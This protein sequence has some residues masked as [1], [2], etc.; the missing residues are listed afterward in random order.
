M[1]TVPAATLGETSC[2]VRNSPGGRRT[3]NSGVIRYDE[4]T[5]E[6]LVPRRVPFTLPGEVTLT[7][8][9]EIDR[10]PTLSSS[11]ELD[12]TE[13][14]MALWSDLERRRYLAE[15]QEGIYGSRRVSHRG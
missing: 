12:Q 13:E 3:I 14:L 6:T 4:T 7:S 5:E 15:E 2:Q 9:K 10:W 8:S 11:P 1:Q